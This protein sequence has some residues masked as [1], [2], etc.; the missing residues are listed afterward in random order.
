M[1]RGC[2]GACAA[3]RASWRLRVVKPGSTCGAGGRSGRG[4]ERSRRLVAAHARALGAVAAFPFVRMVALSGACAHGNA[5]DDDVDVFVITRHGRAWTVTLLLMIASK[6]AGLRRT[7]CVNYVLAEDGLALPEHDSFTA[8]ELVALQPLAGRETYRRFV[9]A[10]AWVAPLHPNFFAGHE[11]ES[12]GVW[13]RAGAA[14]L[15]R[16][17]DVLGIGL[18]ERAARWLLEPYLR[19]RVRGA[20]V[21][22]TARRL[23][24]HGRDHR[25]PVT[26]AFAE[27]QAERPEARSA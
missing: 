12:E 22:L 21:D 18:F 9:Q 23:K 27:A 17:A 3:A 1:G 13:A 7:L 4:A 25:G 24:L 8:S 2:V 11:R 6:L 16:V 19:R 26:R 10:N 15:E 14:R 5:A 20:G